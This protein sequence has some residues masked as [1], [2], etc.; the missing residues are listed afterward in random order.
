MK[1]TIQKLVT[2]LK[3][4]FIE[5]G[6]LE[7]NGSE[8]RAQDIH[9]LQKL[10]ELG[11]AS[12]KTFIVCNCLRCLDRKGEVFG[13]SGGPVANGLNGGAG[14]EGRVHLDCREV[15]SIEG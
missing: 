15:L 10:R 2:I 14:V 13:S 4:R 8:F 12:D 6:E 1:K 5:E 7:N 11:F 3:S 9:R